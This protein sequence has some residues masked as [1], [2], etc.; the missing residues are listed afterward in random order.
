MKITLSIIASLLLSSAWSIA[1]PPSPALEAEAEAEAEADQNTA[2]AENLAK[3]EVLHQEHSALYEGDDQVMIRRGLVADRHT[4]TVT[5][6]GEATGLSDAEPIEFILIADTSGHD[7]EAL[8]VSFARP[9][10]ILEALEFIGMKPGAAFNPDALRYRPKGERVDVTI[11]WVDAEGTAHKWPAEALVMD[12]RIQAPLPETGFVFSGSVWE[13]REGDGRV[14]LPAVNEPKSII[15]TYNETITVL[16]VPRDVPQAMV[17][18]SLRPHPDR[19]M[20]HGQFL[21]IEFRPQRSTDQTPRVADLILAASPAPE[22]GDDL[23]F[24]LT[25]G[26][27]NLLSESNALHNVLAALN[28][29]VDEEREPHLSVQFAPALALRDARHLYALL[30]TFEKTDTLRIEP[31]EPGALF[32]RAFLPNEKHRDRNERPSQALEFHLAPDDAGQLTG[33]IAEIIDQRQN[34]EDPPSWKVNDHPV[35]QPGDVAAKLAEL[36]HS[37]S[38][39]LVFVPATV[40]IHDLMEWLTPA[41]PTH[42]TIHLFLTE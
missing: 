38:V 12:H 10:D 27:T 7:Y 22:N 2:R 21:Q 32:Y 13:E 9:Q 42:P 35:A 6:A 25:E 1:D 39:L 34:R 19:P 30:A 28:R 23:Q 31:P 29:L 17:Y 24:Q 18:G 8:A 37:L 20:T 5:I 3:I 14:Y 40:T 4:A 16:D 41:L 15:S 36:N 33:R 11:A 26:D